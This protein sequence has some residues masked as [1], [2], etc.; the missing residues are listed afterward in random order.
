MWSVILYYCGAEKKIR[1]KQLVMSEVK[2]GNENVKSARKLLNG[3]KCLGGE[4]VC[5][6]A[7]CLPQSITRKDE[8]PQEE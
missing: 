7:A 8:P 6:C 5:P 4:S 1:C 2:K 3:T